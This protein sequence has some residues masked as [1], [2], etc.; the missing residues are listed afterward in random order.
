VKKLPLFVVVVLVFLNSGITFAQED[1]DVP[2]LSDEDI[3][4]L[5]AILP[6]DIPRNLREDR[7]SGEP[8]V[9]VETNEISRLNTSQTLYHLLILD[10]TYSP[11]NS[12]IGGTDNISII[13]KLKHGSNGYLVAIYTSSNEGPVF[14]VFPDR[15][16][17]L[18]DLVT[19]RKNTIREYVN[20][21]AF[22]KFITSR[23]ILTQ[24][25]EALGR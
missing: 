10:R 7:G 8:V 5:E 13:Y 11:R 22:G 1:D 3:A 12:D 19:T 21:G 24:L 20:S 18:V 9:V 4:S 25:R 16:S 23:R 2:Y 14:P 6:D 17:I 15:S